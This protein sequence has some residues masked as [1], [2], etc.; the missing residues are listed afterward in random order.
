MPRWLE[1]LLSIKSSPDWEGGE[2]SLQ[3]QSMPQ[4]L[5]GT[6]AL[7]AA[8]A[9]AAGIWTLYRLEG[10]E[11][12]LL[13]RLL[14]ASL[15]LAVL[16]AVTFMLLELVLVIT[17]REQV[18]SHLLVLIDASQ[19]MSVADPYPSDA[20]AAAVAQGLGLLETDGRPSLAAVRQQPR[21]DLAARAL[22]PLLKPLGDSRVLTIY[23]FTDRLQ[24]E[25]ASRPWT[26]IQPLGSA[27]GLGESLADALAAHRGQPLAGVL[28]V[29]DGRNNSGQ[30]PRSV[31]AAAGREGIP[32]VSLAVGTPE[33]PRNVRLA[34]VEVSPVVFQHD[35]SPLAV[36]VESRG[37][38]DATVNVVLEQRQPDGSWQEIQRQPL[39]LTEDNVLRRAEFTFTPTTLG[40]LEFRARVED[41]GPELTE[42]DNE[43]I[44]QVRVVRQS[45]RVLLLAGYPSFEVQFLRNALL[46][47][48]RLEFSTW[49]QSASEGY[50]HSATRR[51]LRRPPAS[52]QELDYFD[53]VILIDPDMRALGPAWPE[54]LTRFVGE[55]GGGLI[56]VAGEIHSPS[57]FH[58]EGDRIDNSWLKIL[59]VVCE[60]GLYR[61]AAEVRLSSRETYHMEL[62]PAGLADPIFRFVPDTARNREILAS[63]PGMYWYFPVTR[64]KPAAT[65]LAQHGDPRM[66]NQHGRHVLMATQLYGPGRTVFIGFDSSYRWR[67][68]DEGL[69]DGFW[70]R[71]IDRVGRNKV[72]GGR[73]PFLLS[74]DK[75][76]YRVGEQ[77]TLRARLVGSPE[78]LAGLSNL[79]AEVERGG[80]TVL[81]ELDFEPSADDPEVM[82]AT[83][84]ADQPGAFLARVGP[85]GQAEVD[86][87]VRKTT[88]PFRV[89]QPRQELDNPTLDRALLDDLARASGGRVITLAEARKVPAAFKLRTVERIREFREDIW[90]APLICGLAVLLLTAEWLLRKRNR[91]V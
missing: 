91:M 41:A 58:A 12:R 47:D 53:A 76:V 25:T 22:R 5:W 52:Q 36:L 71:L 86:G 4:G 1:W 65:V 20:Q 3:F 57:L 24:T 19:S 34:G 61:T 78:E 48:T 74:L 79:R 90:D 39:L 69:F 37:L 87:G 40:Q 49:L 17:K 89:E 27:T 67:Y 38:R 88:V 82:V 60:A 26:E 7:A 54:M 31:A 13:S 83:F 23:G 29:T 18:P 14:L 16:V 44:E 46:R 59:P 28:L 68:I 15:R 2:W 75:S 11:L 21:F 33:G 9:V 63:L 51:P 30:D 77:V 50:E 70:A 56:Y 55:A 72:L 35:P 85:A 32:I 73:Y 84:T 42:S 81:E 45:I 66:R 64:A 10:R 80:E 6:A 62:T 43:H 8:A